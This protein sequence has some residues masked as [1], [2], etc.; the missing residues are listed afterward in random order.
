MRFRA[1]HHRPH[2][3]APPQTLFIPSRCGC[4]TDYFPVPVGDG[5]WPLVPI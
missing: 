3:W 5:L 2:G 1:E 4:T